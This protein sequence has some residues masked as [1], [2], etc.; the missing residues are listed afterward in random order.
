[1]AA[2]DRW[3]GED[4]FSTFTFFLVHCG[5]RQ[6]VRCLRTGKSQ[7]FGH[8]ALSL[9]R[10]PDLSRRGHGIQTVFSHKSLQNGQNLPG[11]PLVKSGVSSSSPGSTQVIDPD[12]HSLAALPDSL[13][14]SGAA[15]LRPFV[16]SRPKASRPVVAV[17]VFAADTL[18]HGTF[19]GPFVPC[20]ANISSRRIFCYAGCSLWKGENE[21]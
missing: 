12:C 4:I 5:V 15:P 13:R 3:G 1:M 20:A 16:A 8:R 19:P 2:N 18:A 9:S 7:S 10:E 11:P 21:G 17:G 14:S 6:L